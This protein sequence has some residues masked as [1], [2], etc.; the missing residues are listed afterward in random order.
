MDP[1]GNPKDMSGPE[2]KYT[3]HLTT[4]LGAVKNTL[5]NLQTAGKTRNCPAEFPLVVAV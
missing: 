5:K 3:A 1:I 4:A 2:R